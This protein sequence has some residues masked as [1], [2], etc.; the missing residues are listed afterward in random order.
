MLSYN[1]TVI[2]VKDMAQT[3]RFY[4]DLLGQKPKWVGDGYVPYESNLNLW[5]E[6]YL[7]QT[8]FTEGKDPDGDRPGKRRFELYFEEDQVV[9][10]W[11]KMR[12]AGVVCVH[13]VKEMAWGQMVL[14]VY[15]PEGNI[16]EI[17]EPLDTFIGR[18]LKSGLS[19]EETAQR[20]F[21][22]LEIVREIK[23]RLGC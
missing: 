23:D 16:V 8:I 11:E 7:E 19:I 22:T 2:F 14:R 1:G 10:L 3:R 6:Q 15:D 9:D 13:P 18:F 12:A 5:D 21:T 17:G 20:T 4:E